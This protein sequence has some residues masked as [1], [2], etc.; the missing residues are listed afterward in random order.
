[1]ALKFRAA[2]W[3]YQVWDQ[4]ERNWSGIEKHL[5]SLTPVSVYPMIHST[6][7][8]KFQNFLRILAQIGKF[9]PVAVQAFKAI[10]SLF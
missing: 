2:L 3:L 7:S 1:L 4:P 5:F 6:K 8:S 9:V 10:K